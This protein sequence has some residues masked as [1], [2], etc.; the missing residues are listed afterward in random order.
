[1]SGFVLPVH[2]EIEWTSHDAVHRLRVVLGVQEIGHAGTLDPFATGILLCGVGRGTKV[3]SYL[4]DL[5][6]EYVGTM[7][8]GR[9]TDTGDITGETTEERA[10]DG[11]TLERARETAGRFLGVQEQIPPMVSAIKHQGKRLYELARAGIEIERKPRSVE[12]DLFEIPSIEGSLAHFRIVCGKGTYVRAL[13]R[14]FGE[15]IGTG[16]CVETL[17]RKAVGSFDDDQAVRLTGER[18]DILAACAGAS[19]PLAV[20]L[21]HIPGLHLS[22]D[23]VR[24][25]RRGEQPPWRAIQEREIPEAERY[26]ILGPAGDLVALASC[27]AVPGPID[28]PWRDSWE[29]ALDRVL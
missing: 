15:A 9:V 1:M 4:M 5:R 16:A 25:V 23:W 29:L 6:K 13:A 2:K 26:R 11:I 27:D 3:L 8:L 24:R 21:S 7:R 14:D 19:I 12:V 22:G 17:R 10:V 18:E 20:A 28:R